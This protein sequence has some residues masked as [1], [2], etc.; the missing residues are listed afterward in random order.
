[1]RSHVELESGAVNVHF[2][3]WQAPNITL[4]LKRFLSEVI[5][6]FMIYIST[7]SLGVYS[8]NYGCLRHVF[9]NPSSCALR[10]N[11]SGFPAGCGRFTYPL[12]FPGSFLPFLPRV[13][14]SQE[15]REYYVHLRTQMNPWISC[16]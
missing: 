14:H 13:C 6:R 7:V 15:S 2:W 8:R 5:D 10:Q 3:R 9:T 16:E 12:P 4:S 11:C 1:M